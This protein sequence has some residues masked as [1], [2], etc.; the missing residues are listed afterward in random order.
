MKRD[1]GFESKGRRFGF[2]NERERECNENAARM[3]CRLGF[4]CLTLIIIWAY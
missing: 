2:E 3:L 1:L 4:T